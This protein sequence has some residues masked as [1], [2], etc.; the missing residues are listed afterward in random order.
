M[1]NDNN[2]FQNALL[3]TTRA[4]SKPDALSQE[5]NVHNR[6]ILKTLEGEEVTLSVTSLLKQDDGSKL[7]DGHII[8]FGSNGIKSSNTVL[9]LNQ[10]LQGLNESKVWR[11]Y[12]SWIAP[13]SS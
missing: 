8:A 7:I 11:I 1:G 10:E 12:K 3:K 6:V 2:Y 4:S 5:I 9:H 13:L